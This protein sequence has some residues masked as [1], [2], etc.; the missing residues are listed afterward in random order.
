MSA[1]QIDLRELKSGAVE[2]KFCPSREQLDELFSVVDD[3]FRVRD[4]Q[5]FEADLRAQMTDATVH[6]S[7]HVRGDFEYDCGRCLSTRELQV[8]TDVDFVLMSEAEWTNAYGDEEEIALSEEDMDISY[9][10]GDV[11]DL[12]SLIREAVLL[13]FPAFPQCPESLRSE[14]DALY[15]ERVGEETIEELEE[16]KVDL[17]WS[18]LKNLEVTDS[19]K[20]KEIKE[21]EDK[22]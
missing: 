19:G 10:E 21:D 8:D 7:G 2:K 20:V 5:A 9:Y 1:F 6:V 12:G 22:G 14:C 4:Q 15:E 11:V 13:E 17:R 3:D 18:P 16:Q